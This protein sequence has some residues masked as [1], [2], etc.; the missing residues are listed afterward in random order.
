MLPLAAFEDPSVLD[1]LKRSFICNGTSMLH[2][3]APTYLQIEWQ[4]LGWIFTIGFIVFGIAC[5]CWII[6]KL[7][8]PLVIA[9]EPGKHTFHTGWS[10][11]LLV[12]LGSIVSLI[13]GLL[14][15]VDHNEERFGDAVSPSGSSA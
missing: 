6:A 13:A 8:H 9:S 15:S 1:R 4:I 2:D 7:Q 14:A 11:L 12:V 5:A 3:F 10:V